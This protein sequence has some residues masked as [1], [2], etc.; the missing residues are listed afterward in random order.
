[1]L[2]VFGPQSLSRVERPHLQRFVEQLLR[3]GHNPSTV[4]NTITAVRV[5]YRRA[6]DL[7]DVA[8][9]PTHGLRLPASRGR[10]ERI[11]SPEE[12][13][14][15]VAAAPPQDRALWATA[16]YA[17]LRLGELRALDWSHVDF[18]RGVIRVE[19]AWE[20]HERQFITPKSKAGVRSVP[21]AAVLRRRLVEHRLLSGRA[22]GLVFGDGTRPFD[23]SR[24]YA[25]ARNAWIAV[26]LQPITPH[27]AR[28]TFASLMIAAGVNVK[29]LSVYMGHGS[30]A[31]TL[32]RYGHL[33]PG[34]EGDAADRFDALV[35][36]SA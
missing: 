26:E 25:R 30:I 27:E 16:L 6:L 10:R 21:L 28:H 2:P 29:A 33:L 19:R 14:A 23:P 1:M 15:L 36:R 8:V 5:I 24:L 12:A 20:P 11:A 32:D 35:E 7:G 4:R 13:A 3:D 9:N 34:A 17:G 22:S 31:I 18:E